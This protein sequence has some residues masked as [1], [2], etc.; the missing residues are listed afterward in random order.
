MADSL[1][2]A[3][4]ELNE[5]ELR[6]SEYASDAVLVIDND[7]RT[8]AV[9]SN[10]I[11]GVYND[12]NV[13]SVNF[14][15]P[16][17][18]DDVDL[19]D[20]TIQINY[21]APNKVGNVYEV[22]DP[23]VGEDKITFEW[24]LDR[25][26]FLS[27]GTVEFTVC[28]REIGQEGAIIRE[29]NTTIAKGTVLAGLEIEDPEDP[30]AYS[31]L[32]HIKQM[33][34]RV[35]SQAATVASD[36]AKTARI[37][38]DVEAIAEELA[39][40]V[41]EVKEK[42]GTPLVAPTAA[43]MIDQTKIYVYTGSET[44]YTFGNWYYWDGTAWTSGGVYNS[45]GVNTDSTLSVSGM[46]ADAKK[47]GDE[48]SGLKGDKVNKPAAN[49][50]GTN[51]QLLRTK[52]D[53]TTEWVDQGLPTDEQ[54][55]EAVEAWLNDH[56]EATTTVE[57]GSITMQK[58]NSGV[59]NEI[60]KKTDAEIVNTSLSYNH[61]GLIHP[62]KITYYGDSLTFGTAKYSDRLNI[63]PSAGVK[64]ISAQDV[65][66]AINGNFVFLDGIA[67][68]SGGNA[69]MQNVSAG[70]HSPGT[71][72][73]VIYADEGSSVF[74]DNY[75]CVFTL[76]LKDANGNV[77]GGYLNK[78]IVNG[79]N[80]WD[81]PV[82]AAFDRVTFNI[83]VRSGTNYNGY[84]LWIG[85]FP[86]DVT[87]VDTQETVSSGSTYEVS[88][89]TNAM[90]EMS[91]IMHQ[92]IVRTAIGEQDL[93][94]LNLAKKTPYITPE[95]YGAVG[96][97]VNDDG[98]F[99][100]Q[101]IL[102]GVA[103][104]R[105]VLC[106]KKYL[107]SIPIDIPSYSYLI[108]N[109]LTYTGSDS[110]VLVRGR[111]N[112]IDVRRI[113]SSGTGL[114][115]RGDSTS[116]VIYNRINAI[117]ISAN[118]DGILLSADTRAVS[119]N[120]IN[121]RCISAG[122]NSY[123]GIC[124]G[125][126]N[127]YISENTFRGG[128]IRNA[129]YAFKEIG[130]NSRAENIDVEGDIKGGFLNCR[131][132]IVENDR[133]WECC[134]NSDEPYIKFTADVSSKKTLDFKFNSFN[135]LPWNQIDLSGCVKTYDGGIKYT[136]SDGMGEINCPINVYVA[137][138]VI[139]S[140]EYF[141]AFKAYLFADAVIFAPDREYMLEVNEDLDL[142]TITSQTKPLATIFVVSDADVDIRLH[143]SYCWM[144]ISKFTVSQ[145]NSHTAKVYEWFGNR[146]VFDGTNLGDGDFE[147]ECY[148]SSKNIYADG[149]NMYWRYK[150]ITDTYI[151][152]IAP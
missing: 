112:K 148:I 21:L 130:G 101:A 32:V 150:K 102:A 116:G 135:V 103:L 132:L 84:K 58:L 118:K 1:L 115:F 5:Q 79:T 31:L 23:V 114:E 76:N 37:A 93:I 72:R 40:D 129:H 61:S 45:A 145:Q 107:S 124:Q 18:Y 28:L 9:P 119:S 39:D 139:G 33:D 35:A 108:L 89:S 68:N 117:D 110:A 80:S 81:M 59:Q 63:F 48:I 75:H 121:F 16:R 60:N 105:I 25:G 64:T 140:N 3:L 104:D 126:H 99:I 123:Y 65:N 136:S 44:G 147:I 30:E 66:Y 106:A 55:A 50:N 127:T 36:Y 24:L 47:T 90:T 53:G 94:T 100:N 92:S 78:K 51:G 34:E 4:E 54:T 15:M 62:T 142:R 43:D 91:S 17:T 49:P 97:G 6:A 14:E 143:S 131:G 137:N 149:S 133:H 86:D 69:Y 82:E 113:I 141:F 42:Y 56:P 12:K 96:D 98:A 52:G 134:N 70:S 2:A 38:D 19:S 73:F 125:V 111:N 11:F 95:E 41:A 10:F 128:N 8:I 13:L 22:T 85:L 144:G 29:F 83:Q 67:S 120:E 122:G 138:H 27:S 71:Y 74:S 146:C 26:V 109:E 151:D 7:L 152:V 20:F 88:L 87:I 46:P 77:T 57:N